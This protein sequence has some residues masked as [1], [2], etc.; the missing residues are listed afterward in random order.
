MT[1]QERLKALKRVEAAKLLVTTPGFVSD[2]IHAKRIPSVVTINKAANALGCDD[3][4]IG[5]SVRVWA[6]AASIREMYP[7]HSEPAN[8][9]KGAA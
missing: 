1:I 7:E 3:A 6:E 2:L 5:A 8:D 4:E 9:M